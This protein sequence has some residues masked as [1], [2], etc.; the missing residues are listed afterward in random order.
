M[1]DIPV[2]KF[3]YRCDKKFIVDS[4]MS[5]YESYDSHAVVLISGRIIELYKC[6]PV[7]VQLIARL[8]LKI[9]NQ[10]RTGGQ[11]A[12]RFDR[13]RSEAI[14]AEVSKS[15]ELITDKCIIDGRFIFQSIIIA[16][17]VGL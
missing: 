5:L 17:S 2:K 7:N 10:H 9:P 13:M 1:P 14:I 6:T 3:Y 16:G 11:S 4:A 12:Q 15:I 8:K